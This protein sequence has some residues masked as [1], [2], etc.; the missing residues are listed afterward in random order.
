MR[1]FLKLT[2]FI[3]L[4]FLIVFSFGNAYDI[5]STNQT[6][7]AL[8]GGSLP[9]IFRTL[10]KPE[11]PDMEI[12]TVSFQLRMDEVMHQFARHWPICD[13]SLRLSPD[14]DAPS[15]KADSLSSTNETNPNAASRQTKNEENVDSSVDE[16]SESDNNAESKTMLTCIGVT[17]DNRHKGPWSLSPENDNTRMNDQFT[18]KSNLD[19]NS[20]MDDVRKT[21]FKLSISSPNV[22]DVSGQD[23]PFSIMVTSSMPRES[24]SFGKVETCL[25]ATKNF[26]VTDDLSGD[27]LASRRLS[28][29]LRLTALRIQSDTSGGMEKSGDECGVE[30]AFDDNAN[31]NKPTVVD[32]LIYLPRTINRVPIKR[33][34]SSDNLL[35]NV[36][37]V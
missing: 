19:L 1:K 11:K 36:H 27:S 9:L 8:A 22:L 6:I 26:D 7:A 23:R 14:A 2:L 28:K 13:L 20:A 10:M 17:P 3:L 4:V 5:S 31:A 30:E 32:L 15:K 34:R 21:R 29:S 12:G 35:H 37:S 25:L 24:L 16:D 18:G 33:K